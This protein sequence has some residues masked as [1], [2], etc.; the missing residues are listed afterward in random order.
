MRRPQAARNT[1]SK[2]FKAKFIRFLLLVGVLGL[3]FNYVRPLPV[4]VASIVGLKANAETVKLQWPAQGSAAIAADGFGVLGTHGPEDKRPTASLAKIITVLAVLEKHP[5]KKGQKGPDLK[6][7][8]QDVA[9]FNDYFAKGGSYVKVEAGEKI[10]L[11]QALQAILL[12]SANNMADSVA[13]WSFGSLEKYVAYANDMVR[14]LG[15][16]NTVVATDASGFSPDTLST[17]T[18]LVRLGQVAM[19]NAV[20]AEIVAQRS[21]TIPVHGIIYSANSR[22]GYDNIIGIKTGLTDEAGGCFLFAAKYKPE[23]AKTT[24]PVMLVGVITGAPTLRAALADSEPLIDSAKPYFS[25]KTAVRAGEVFA[26]LTTPWRDSAKVIAKQDI[27]LLAWRGKDLNPHV[28]LA[29]INRSLPEG[30]EVGTAIVASGDS[31]A[32]SPLV[33]QKAIDGPSW[34]WRMARF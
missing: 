32:T 13:I 11:Y 14:R 17:P 19:R 31:R 10:S 3:L 16:N 4:G 25:V 21:A 22:L 8:Q 20:I 12:P 5:L 6:L 26:T 34:Q 28:R 18:D 29:P 24:R 27:T 23:A 2:R 9:L 1:R 7:T 33:L 30:A 15:L